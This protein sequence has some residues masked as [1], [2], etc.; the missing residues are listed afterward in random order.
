MESWKQSGLV[1]VIVIAAIVV[2]G[3]IQA[4]SLKHAGD[5]G[6]YV[7][8]AP[9]RAGVGSPVEAGL[10]VR[11]GPATGDLRLPKLDGVNP[12]QGTPN[13]ISGAAP[14]AA[15]LAATDAVRFKAQGA[16]VRQGPAGDFLAVARYLSDTGEAVV[17]SSWTAS[18]P[19]D[20]VLP[21][22]SPV[23]DVRQTTLAGVPV[24]LVLS[25]EGV[26]G[27]PPRR[28]YLLANGVACLIEAE[29]FSSNQDVIDLVTRIAQ[30]WPTE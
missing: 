12:V 21:L 18:G 29:G 26:I 15:I 10:R 24:V 19:L 14:R 1:T 5:S 4:W 6:V 9:T 11:S 28:A 16:E 3:G 13:D 23:I 25:V 8:T 17:L 2:G 27:K 22:Q 7:Q 20:I 30:A